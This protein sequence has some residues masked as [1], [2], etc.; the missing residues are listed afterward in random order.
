LSVRAAGERPSL[1]VRPYA[2]FPMQLFRRSAF[3]AKLYSVAIV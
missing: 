2:L 1:G 3:L